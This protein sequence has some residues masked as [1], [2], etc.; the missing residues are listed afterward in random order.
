MTLKLVR[1]IRRVKWS[2]MLIPNYRISDK[3]KIHIRQVKEKYYKF[4]DFC[5]LIYSK[6]SIFRL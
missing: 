3:D 5:D 6:S 1:I 2:F 4:I